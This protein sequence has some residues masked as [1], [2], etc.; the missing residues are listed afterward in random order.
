[1]EGMQE[2]SLDAVK[3]AGITIAPVVNAASSSKNRSAEV[4]FLWWLEFYRQSFSMS[5]TRTVES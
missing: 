3:Q 2:I 1:M 4:Q 5:T